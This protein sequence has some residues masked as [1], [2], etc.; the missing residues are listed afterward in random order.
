MSSTKYEP[1][2][3]EAPEPEGSH[4]VAV[5]ATQGYDSDPEDPTC[6]CHGNKGG[7]VLSVA[8]LLTIAA[9][10]IAVSSA[11]LGGL[12]P[13]LDANKDVFDNRWRSNG[14]DVHYMNENSCEYKS[15]E[16]PYKGDSASTKEEIIARMQQVISCHEKVHQE[17]TKYVT[18]AIVVY[19]CALLVG[20]Y[21][22]ATGVFHMT[23]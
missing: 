18:A 13:L 2:D 10:W 5:R 8:V 21:I 6:A 9:A 3:T 17:T 1:V 16:D 14:A 12:I 20:A 23:P 11:L 7:C 22:G 4:A 19:P 15:Y